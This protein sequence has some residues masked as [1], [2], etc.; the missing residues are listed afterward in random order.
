MVYPQ[1][2][3]ELSGILGLIGGNVTIEQ[4][5]SLAGHIAWPIVALIALIA[6][7]PYLSQ[8][9]R[10]AADLRDL[11]NR[12]G[13]M[14]DL[15]S[16]VAALSEATNDLK[17]MQ[18]VE[19]AGRPEVASQS[20]AI[21]TDAL[22]K[23]LEAEW[24]ETRDAFRTVAKSAGVPV[25][26]IGVIKVREAATALTEKGILDEA[27]A[28]AMVDLSAQYQYLYRTTSDRS[29]ILNENALAAYIKSATRVRVALKAR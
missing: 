8:L 13:E 10:A 16:Q 5:I 1:A 25:N 15:V 20:G 27:T 29:E 23:K 6:L 19:R 9:T 17:A 22:W 11:L 4:G 28:S 2:E 3:P 21:S 26:F 7:L 24:Q 14:V 12:S 18:Q